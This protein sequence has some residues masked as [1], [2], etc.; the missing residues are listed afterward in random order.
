MN[1]EPSGKGLARALETLGGRAVA[2]NRVMPVVS[3][4]EAS[5]SHTLPLSLRGSREKFCKTSTF[6]GTV[7]FLVGEAICLKS[8]A[9]LY[10]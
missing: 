3:V 8:K 7:S 1:V 4:S 10:L 9:S 2:G 6:T 5:N